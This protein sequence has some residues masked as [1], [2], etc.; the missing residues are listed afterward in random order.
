[1]GLLILT[2]IPRPP[3]PSGGL[4]HHKERE[5]SDLGIGSARYLNDFF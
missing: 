3:S 5:H 1:M 4:H 2:T